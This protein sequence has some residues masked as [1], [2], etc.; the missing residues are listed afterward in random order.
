LLNL[1]VN[2]CEAIADNSGIV[3]VGIDIG[4]DRIVTVFVTDNGPGI[5]KS[6]INRI[7]DPFYSTKKDGTGL[8]LSIV[9]RL[10]QNLNIEMS[11]RTQPGAGT[12]FILGFTHVPVEANASNRLKIAA[13][14]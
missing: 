2:A 4:E 3:T 14:S 10:A 5:E 8:G 11:F 7:F 13:L 6:H 12:T 9:Q 1:L